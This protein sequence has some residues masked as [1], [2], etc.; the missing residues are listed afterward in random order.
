MGPSK[1]RGPMGLHQLL[2]PTAVLAPLIGGLGPVTVSQFNLPH[3]LFLYKK[4]EV[5]EPRTALSSLEEI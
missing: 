3:I 1:A 2:W 5:R 4:K